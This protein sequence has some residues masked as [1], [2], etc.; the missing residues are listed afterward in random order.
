MNSK[1]IAAIRSEA[2]VVEKLVDFKARFQNKKVIAVVI[3][4]KTIGALKM[5][6]GVGYYTC[7][8]NGKKI[9]VEE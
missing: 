4:E 7:V 1:K 2:D 5:L 6:D 9:F 3:A 8:L